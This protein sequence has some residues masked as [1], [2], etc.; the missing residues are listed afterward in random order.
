MPKEYA[1]RLGTFSM[2]TLDVAIGC[3]MKANL[4]KEVASQ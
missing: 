4:I 2:V 1:D 3:V